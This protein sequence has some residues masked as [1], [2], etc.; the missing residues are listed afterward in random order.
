MLFTFATSRSSL[1]VSIRV[2]NL[3][4]QKLVQVKLLKSFGKVVVELAILLFMIIVVCYDRRRCADFSLLSRLKYIFYYL[5]KTRETAIYLFFHEF[6]VVSFA[7][8][9]NVVRST[10]PDCSNENGGQIVAAKV[11]APK[12]EELYFSH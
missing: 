5:K 9:F 3:A 10:V 4:G 8:D 6:Q 11:V 12:N 7:E 2:Q 1:V